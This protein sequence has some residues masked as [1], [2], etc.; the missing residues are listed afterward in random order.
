MMPDYIMTV[1][2][3]LPEHDTSG[4]VLDLAKTHER[5]STDISD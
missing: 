4:L 1:R 5:E 3:G 2:F